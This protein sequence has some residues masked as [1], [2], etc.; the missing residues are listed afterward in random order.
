MDGHL[1]VGRRHFAAAHAA[2]LAN[3]T[4]LTPLAL[5]RPDARGKAPA[6]A[7]PQ[8]GRLKRALA[9][10]QDERQDPALP[11]RLCRRRGKGQVR[12]LLALGPFQRPNES[13]D[14]PCPCA[15]Q[16]PWL[17]G[18]CAGREQARRFPDL[19]AR[20]A[21]QVIWCVGSRTHPSGCRNLYLIDTP[22]SLEFSALMQA[23][24]P[25]LAPP[26]RTRSRPAST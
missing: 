15:S 9:R 7:L 14:G 13:A 6:D 22:S 21:A 5:L 16:D 8:D 12:P 2:P 19:G 10:Q 23:F 18:F 17:R 26:G 25:R 3:E 1:A 20:A 24:C 11:D 4:D